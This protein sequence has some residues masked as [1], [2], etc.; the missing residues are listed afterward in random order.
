MCDK[1]T[2]S[3]F[4]GQTDQVLDERTYLM[5]DGQ[6][7]EEQTCVTDRSTK[8]ICDG[9]TDHM[10]TRQTA[11]LSDGHTDFMFDGQTDVSCDGQTNF[12]FGFT[13]RTDRSHVLKT[14]RSYVTNRPISMS[15]GQTDFL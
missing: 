11:L 14:G 9:Q 1:L 13:K 15:D 5:C 4:H 2:D 10:F 6:T 8:F 12:M 7:C 3:M